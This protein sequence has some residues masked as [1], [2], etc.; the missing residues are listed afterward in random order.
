M[1]RGCLVR[2]RGLWRRSECLVVDSA[3]LSGKAGLKI[4]TAYLRGK[5]T[6]FWLIASPLLY[7]VYSFSFSYGV[8]FGVSPDLPKLM[9]IGDFYRISLTFAALVAAAVIFLYVIFAMNI[10]MALHMFGDMKK[11]TSPRENGAE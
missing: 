1:A 10:A 9:T 3:E 6:R 7:S 5:S 2:P 4:L 8:A 11:T